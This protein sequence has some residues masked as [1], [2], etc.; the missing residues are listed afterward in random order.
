MG[1]LKSPSSCSSGLSSGWSSCSAAHHLPPVK[2]EVMPWPWITAAPVCPCGKSNSVLS[3]NLLLSLL[4]Q[5][6]LLV[7]VQSIQMAFTQEI[8]TPLQCPAVLWP[9]RSVCTWSVGL[10]LFIRWWSGKMQ[11]G[12][13]EW[14]FSL[15]LLMDLQQLRNVSLSAIHA[16]VCGVWKPR[17]RTVWKCCH[18][19]VQALAV[20]SWVGIFA[21]FML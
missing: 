20:F 3:W 7:F 14:A 6:V 17:F 8:C 1:A 13:D 12:V 21:P 19:H 18:C 11:T 16:S 10:W 5:N 2:A 9:Q 15:A 4:L